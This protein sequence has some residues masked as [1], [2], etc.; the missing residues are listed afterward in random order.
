MDDKS[1]VLG[2]SYISEHEMLDFLSN[3]LKEKED[4]Q[5]YMLYCRTEE[6]LTKDINF[7]KSQAK[8]IEKSEGSP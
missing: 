8:K 7:L 4:E 1:F 5:F 6:K 3:W 2:N